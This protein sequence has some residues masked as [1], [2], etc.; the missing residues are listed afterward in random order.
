MTQKIAVAIVHGIGSQD[1]TF[2]DKMIAEL[3]WRCGEQVSADLVMRGVHWA[4]ILRDVETELIARTTAGGPQRQAFL[5]RFLIE[6]MG[7]A[8]AYQPVR[9]DRTVYDSIHALIAETLRLLS[10]EAGPYAPLCIVAHS[11]GTIIASNFI[12]DLQVESFRPMIGERTREEMGSPATPLEAGETL[13]LL[14]TLG[15]PLAIWS[16]RYANF[17][18][19]ITMPAPHL[20]RYFPDLKGE[21]VNFYDADDMVGFP[22]KTLNEYYGAMVTEDRPVNVGRIIESWNPLSHLGYW[23]DDDILE[24]IAGSLCRVWDEVNPQAF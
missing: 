13:S 4:P 16:L 21:W 3:R 18:K 10:E 20:N 22:I 14:Y 6:L 15:S 1:Q 17:G 12:Y 11:L 7:D 5:R 9:S 24:P 19:P 23:T 8:F 2:A